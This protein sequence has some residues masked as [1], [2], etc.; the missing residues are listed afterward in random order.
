MGFALPNG[1]H[2]YLAS[3]YGPAITFTGA[4]NAEHA[5]ITV[6]AADDIAVG[7]GKNMPLGR[8]KLKG[9]KPP[10]TAP[11]PSLRSRLLISIARLQRCALLMTICYR[12]KSLSMTLIR[13]I[14]MR[15]TFQQ[16]T[17]QLIR[18]RSESEFFTL[19]AKAAKFR[20]KVSNSYSI[21][22]CHYRER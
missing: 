20:A 9:L 15:R 5:V 4:T 7:R 22:R 16:V 8:I 6:S 12:R 10:Q 18:N 1:A 21:A 13:I 14:S 17:Q 19:I 11:V 2:V 3:G